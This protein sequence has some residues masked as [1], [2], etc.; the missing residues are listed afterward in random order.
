MSNLKVFTSVRGLGLSLAATGLVL[1]ALQRALRPSKAPTE[2]APPAYQSPDEPLGDVPAGRLGAHRAAAPVMRQ[3][4]TRV[5]GEV[6]SDAVLFYC[7]AV[8]FLESTYGKGW[9]AASG[10]AACNNWGAVQCRAPGQPGCVESTDHTSAH[11][12]FKTGFRC[13]G[14]PLEGAEDVAKSIMK[15]RPATRD[16]LTG[17]GAN[18]YRASYAMRRETYYGGFCPKAVSRYGEQAGSVAALKNPDRDEGST[19][20]AREAIEAHAKTA[21]RLMR[22]IALATERNVPLPLGDFANADAWYRERVGVRA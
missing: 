4:L 22:E 13:Y 2:E 12:E 15:A 5:L 6:P 14:T 17:R 9:S 16:A 21:Y 11:K 20:C 7:M 18:V 3:A 19:A 10:I 8:A 1:L